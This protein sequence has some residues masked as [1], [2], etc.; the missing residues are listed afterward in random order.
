M[1]A[2]PRRRLTAILASLRSAI[3][4][5]IRVKREA[6]RWIDVDPMAGRQSCDMGRHGRLPVSRFLHSQGGA[7]RRRG[8]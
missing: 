7:G 4:I 2:L 8:C 6:T 5:I 1:T 3:I